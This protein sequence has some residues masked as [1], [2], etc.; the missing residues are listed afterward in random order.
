VSASSTDRS[1]RAN[2]LSRVDARIVA[3]RLGFQL[4]GPLAP[5]RAARAAERL[6]TRP[7]Q[8]PL[9]PPEE[10]FLDT[11]QPFQVPHAGQVL[12][13]W[14]WGSG[15]A[16]LLMHGWGSRAGR[17][18]LF[19]PA[20]Q[21]R[22][23]RAI[24]FDG[25]G[26]GRT[27]GDSAS[28]PQFAAAI[29]AVNEAVGP[30]GAFIGHSLGGAAALFAM[31]RLVPHVPAVLISAPSDPV[32]FWRRFVRHLAIPRAVRDRLQRNLEERFGITWGDLNLIPVAAALPSPLL[33]IHDEGDED[34]PVDEG[35]ELAAA[36]PRGSFV[37]TQG[38]GHRAIMRDAA[39]VELAANFISE[40]VPR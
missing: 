2:P 22:G 27:G 9:R 26:H 10:A 25:P 37:L 6:F 29:A 1:P 39:V 19:V 15:P 31:G 28:L 34:V 11:G 13:G 32:V 17:F 35:R 12:S 5:G 8:H 4:L 20:L 3:L 18:R 33:V 40:H 7:P 14:S 16:V 24:A 21:A 30:V 36:A 23:F 38:L